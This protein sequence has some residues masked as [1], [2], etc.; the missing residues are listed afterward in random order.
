MKYSLHNGSLYDYASKEVSFILSGL[1]KDQ[2]ALEGLNSNALGRFL[3]S[4]TDTL[5]GVTTTFASNIFRINK[6]L[7]R[8]ELH[9]F[10]D[11][12]RLKVHTVDQIA[13]PR[14]V[15][16]K[17]DVPA[18]LRGTY[19]QAIDS[20][21]QIYIKLNTF[22]VA[23]LMK[24][25]LTNIF[26]SLTNGDQKSAG[27]ISSTAHIVAVTVQA[28]KPAIVDAQQNFGGKFQQKANFESIFLS[29]EEWLECQRQLLD[30][31]PRLREASQIHDLIISMEQT[32]KS[33]CSFMNDNP[34]K[35]T[36]RDLTIFGE[37]IK[38]VA[39]VMD[40]YNM[41]IMRHLA[42]EHNYVLMVNAIYSGVK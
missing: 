9:E 22:N 31:E 1:P 7:K 41:A 17:V 14:L 3:V 37:M 10:I 11:S 21:N 28:S 29:K 2:T 5:L 34:D 36:S 42:L 27:L 39:L 13:Y 4:L 16:F 18:N 40:G 25:S 32:L 12:N 23:K 20:I 19:K 26:T 33:V 8:S 30:L 35:L 6:A 15:G 38:N 24:T